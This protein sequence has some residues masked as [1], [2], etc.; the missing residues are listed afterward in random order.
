MRRSAHASVRCCA[1]AMALVAPLAASALEPGDLL[2]VAYDSANP[3]S[4]HFLTL[5]D[6]PSGAEVT[7][8]DLGWTGTSFRPA[9]VG[10][11]EG[12]VLWVPSADVPIGTEVAL[13]TAALTSSFPATVTGGGFGFTNV[14]DQVLA[15]DGTSASPNFL[16]GIDVAG[17]WTAGATAFNESKLPTALIG[18]DV[19]ILAAPKNATYNCNATV[20]GFPADLVA[21]IRNSSNWI[22]SNTGLDGPDCTW[23]VNTCGDGFLN[24]DDVCDGPELDGADCRDEGYA[25]A[26]S[27]T[28]AVDCLS[29][30]YSTCTNTCG[31]GNDEPGE[32]C[33]GGG[34]NTA[35][36]DADCTLVESG[37][38]ICN[39]AADEN[40]ANEPGCPT[41]CGDDVITGSEVCDGDNLA[42]TDC[43]DSGFV[44]AAGLE[45]S[46]SCLDF[47]ESGCTASCGNSIQEPGESCDDGPSGSASCTAQCTL[48]GCDDGTCDRPAETAATCPQDCPAVCGDNTITHDELCDG[49]EMDGASCL[50]LGF[51]D[52]AG[53]VCNDTC[54][55]LDTTDCV[56]T[57]GDGNLEPTEDCDDGNSNVD[58][59]CNDDCAVEDGFSCDDS[60]PSLCIADTDGDGVP[61]TIDNCPD[62][63][64]DDQ[65]DLDDN[66][67]GDAC[68]GGF[69]SDTG[70]EIRCAC[71][72]NDPA[73]TWLAA[74][75][76][77]LLLRRRRRQ[78]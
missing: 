78:R 65:L 35:S 33:D 20:S 47:D 14:G 52:A 16:A 69:D 64:N 5:V 19:S 41:V 71:A 24:G 17:G 26:Q 56:A 3:D 77:L 31:D 27:V 2:F 45:C 48:V 43:T 8:T 10:E 36:C 6:I 46:G 42:G 67:I 4:I 62:E 18:L 29:I 72:T 73:S 7:F 50:D 15:Y 1:I 13:E 61:D 74:L 76:A 44:A 49:V 9:G 30:D 59:G 55:G 11:A 58:D 53:S 63:P 32:A 75:P 40:A 21:A 51:T 70:I 66:G 22:G 23:T 60:S 38:G 12:S 39:T 34:I 28:C 25:A 68:E 54:D 57:C 37:D